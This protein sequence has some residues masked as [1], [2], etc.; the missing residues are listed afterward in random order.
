MFFTRNTKIPRADR[1]LT[2][3]DG[4]H[5]LHFVPEEI[6]R[7]QIFVNQKGNRVTYDFKTA[8]LNSKAI[9][10][11]FPNLP[12]YLSKNIKIKVYYQLLL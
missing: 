12:S 2:K 8:I 1:P 4:V 10:C 11:I 9:P 7:N 3:N 6:I 5:E